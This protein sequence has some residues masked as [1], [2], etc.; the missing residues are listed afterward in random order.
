MQTSTLLQ[1]TLLSPCLLA[2]S[3]LFQPGGAS[4]QAVFFPQEQQAGTAELSE[5]AGTLTLSNQ[6]IN[7]SFV[8]KDN[9]IT[10]GGCPE[11]SLKSGSEI[12]TITLGDGTTVVP[13]SEMTV[14]EWGHTSLTGDPDATVASEKLDGQC[15]YA[16]LTYGDLEF[17]WKAILRDG[18]HYIR[19]TLAITASKDVAMH[20]IIPMTYTIPAELAPSVVGNTR[21]AIL[22]SDK[23]FAGLE[24][25]T[26]IN[27]VELISTG[28]STTPSLGEI[29]V[30]DNGFLLSSWRRDTT[31]D[32]QP[33]SPAY[34]TWQPGSQTPD[35]IKAL[36]F[37]ASDIRGKRGFIAASQSGNHTVT[38]RYTDGTHGLNVVGVDL[39]DTSGEVVASDYH[40][41]FTGGMSRDNTF[42]LNIPEAGTYLVR[43]FVEIKT[44]TIT[45]NGT[46]TW[47]PSVSTAQAPEIP[48]VGDGSG[49]ESETSNLRTIQGLWSRHATLQAGKTWEV[50]SVIGL[51][52]PDQARRS[53]LA[54]SERERAV[55]WRAFPMYNS[56]YELNIDRNNSPSYTGHMTADDCVNVVNQWRT[57][58]YDNHGANIKSF[59]W[60]DGWDEYGTWTF[61]KNFP[62]GFQEPNEAAVA[63]NS[64]IGAWLGPVG[65]YGTS[66]ELRRSYWTNKGGMQLSNPAYYKVFLDAC[67]NMVDNYDFNFF[68]LDGISAQFSSVGPDAGTTGEENAEGIIDILSQVR[69]I[70]PDMFFN[71]TVGTWAS[72]FWFHFTDAVWRQEADWSTIGNQGDDRERWITYRDHLV[73]QNFVS[74]SPLC[75]I[76]T[77]MTHGF[78]LTEKGDVSKS[79]DYDGIVREMRCAF[80]CGSGMVELYCDAKL[81]NSINNGALW[82]DLAECIKWQEKNADVLPDIHWVGGDPWDG[83][84]ANVYGWASWNG[85]KATLAL[86]NPSTSQT[87]YTFTLREAL[88]IP[89]YDNTPVYFAPAFE[90]QNELNGFATYAPISP[91]A[92]ISVT[93]PGSSVY[94]FD[95]SITQIEQ[96]DEKD[97]SSIFITKP[98]HGTLTVKNGETIVTSGKKVENGTVLTIEATP[99]YGYM[100]DKIQVNNNE[101]D[102]NSFTITE[103]VEISATFV[104]DPSITAIYQQP[105]GNV[106]TDTY[107]ESISSTD[108]R[109]NISVDFNTQPSQ[110]FNLIDQTLAVEPGSEFTLTLKAHSLGTG[111]YTAVRQDLRYAAAYVFADWDG[112]A[113]FSL[114]KLY[115]NLPPTHN[116]YG[117][118]D[119]VMNINHTFNVPATLSDGDKGRIRI[120]YAN[121]WG[122]PGTTGF[123]SASAGEYA[124]D[125]N[126]QF[127]T[128]GVCYDIP[129]TVSGLSAIGTIG[130]DGNG[131]ARYYNLQ[132]I[133]VDEDNLT[134][135]FYIMQHGNKS[136]KVF[137]NR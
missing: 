27:S 119:E 93:I 123:L 60:D 104:R 91:D 83:S 134:S 41:G 88:D 13:A 99:D 68:K 11:L 78:I 128:D 20:N 87:T 65:G 8:N 9:K 64:G 48:S 14:T 23:I 37:T 61:N 18:S 19:T 24:T 2:V 81:L 112:T 4:A 95:G 66:G 92:R 97:L 25:P 16:T 29:L 56:W 47:S 26:G 36:G 127:L 1:K 98:D 28:G 62:N 111:S 108:A 94:V 70:R 7:A 76:N 39:V 89:A 6:L 114:I 110:V 86:R 5:S 106:R 109:Q 38:F 43:Y 135:G 132:G 52:A 100:L 129:F 85:S 71:T 54:Y 122:V 126:S 55:P 101:L 103:A 124:C 15:I 73:Y 116:V 46:I 33:A 49:N 69:K 125:P 90:S 53:V 35:G 57:N 79:M 136:E 21:G 63:M 113:N 42:T 58:L 31:E 120:I 67:Q 59:V 107:V 84:K 80:A 51:I 121:A 105:D 130:S 50:S 10:F 32:T 22:A 34:W 131:K 117:N 133:A 74:N 137:I 82:G 12:F 3:L 30:A 75:P 77:L 102:G 45:A 115:G 44:E 72:P 118:Y 40:I 96:P 17:E